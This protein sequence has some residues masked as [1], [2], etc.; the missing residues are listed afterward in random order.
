MRE[1]LKNLQMLNERNDLLYHKKFI[2]KEEYLHNLQIILKRIRNVKSE[3]RAKVKQYPRACEATIIV[4]VINPYF[5]DDKYF[6]SL[7]KIMYSLN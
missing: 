3:P 7:E 4:E 2:S 6:I 1:N 5:K